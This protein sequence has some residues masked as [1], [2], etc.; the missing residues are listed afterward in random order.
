MNK[1]ALLGNAQAVYMV[2]G[3]TVVWAAFMVAGFGVHPYS[4]VGAAVLV[5]LCGW[6][7]VRV[8]AMVPRIRRLPDP[9]LDD[10]ARQEERRM[11][12]VFGTTFGT[13]IVLIVVASNVLAVVG[14]FEY[15]SSVIALIV[16]AHFVPLGVLFRVR[17]YIL[18]GLTVVVVALVGIVLIAAG[19]AGGLVTGVVCLTTALLTASSAVFL[20]ALIARSTA[21]LEHSQ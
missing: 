13:E 6:L 2:S 7:I 11:K 19:R 1:R 15:I 21:T 9:P 10:A 3:F 8:T 18:G 14:R 5:G 12:R 16:A 20:T 4:L 17:W